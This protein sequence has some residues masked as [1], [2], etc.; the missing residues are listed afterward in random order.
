MQA[1]KVGMKTTGWGPVTEVVG[2][3]PTRQDSDD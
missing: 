1:M 2:A 3:T